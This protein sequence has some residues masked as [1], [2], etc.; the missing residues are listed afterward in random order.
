MP[1]Y[2]AP[3]RRDDTDPAPLPFPATDNGATVDGSSSDWMHAAGLP[4]SA[5]QVLN[6]IDRMSRR[7]EDL[8]RELNCLGHFDNDDDRPRA[9]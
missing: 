8:A 4:Q 1:R 5:R 9:A 6:S 7:I 3:S 2:R